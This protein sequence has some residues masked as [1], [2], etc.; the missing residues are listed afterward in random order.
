[1]GAW[2]EDMALWQDLSEAF[3]DAVAAVGPSVVEVR[4]RR[5]PASG[6]SLGGERVVTASHVIQRD[7]EL[8]VV[9]ADGTER[10]AALIGRDVATDLAVLGVPGLAAPAVRWAAAPARP[11]MLVLP[12]ARGAAGV[13]VVLGV[14]SA[15][16]GG[17]KTALGG[18]IDTW[19][20]VHADL[21]PGFSGGPLIGPTGEVLGLDTRGLTPQGA[22]LPGATVSRVAA[23][24]EARGRVAPGYLGVGFYPTGGS[25]EQLV[26]VS[27]EPGGPGEA[28]GVQVGDLLARFDGIA[29]DGI[30]HLLGLL[31]AKGAGATVTLSLTRGG[32]ARDVQI[33]LAARPARLGCR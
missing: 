20:D 5:R 31:S 33:A 10:P 27:V 8:V 25:P 3:A 19:I 9:G 30:R 12:A 13:R 7:E 32:E 2:G 15:V 21:P 22:V 28:A 23:A 24:I 11:G 6:L 26:V 17:W 29:V 14:V 18:E 16:G 4:G 1:M